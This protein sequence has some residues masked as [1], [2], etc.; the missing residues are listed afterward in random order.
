VVPMRKSSRLAVCPIL[1]ENKHLKNILFLGNDVSGFHQYFEYLPREKVLL[2]FPG[3]GG[4]Y[5]GQ[6][7]VFVDTEKPN[8]KKGPI[9]MGELDGKVR[10]R[11]KQIKEFFKSADQPIHLENDIDGWLKYHFAFIGPIAGL[12]F[13]C[14]LDFQA[15][16]AD[17]EGI[18]KYVLACREAGNVLK[19]VGYTKR[20]PFIFNIFYWL[21]L[22]LAPTVFKRQ[23]SSRHAEVGM[24]LHA[25]AIGSEL[26]ELMEE[27]A[28]L[29][30]KAGI[31]TPNLDE[32]LA[33][34][35][36]E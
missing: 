34:V 9:F 3:A 2:G 35:P 14:N 1:A 22:F 32:L 36:S 12:I 26:H 17:K 8:G 10:E 13:K 33:Y 11:T 4:G 28:E 19:R 31:K 6:D 23:F 7:L 27:F 29:K 30:K 16:A 5:D 24:G 18:K 21:P 25:K 15:V 20:Q